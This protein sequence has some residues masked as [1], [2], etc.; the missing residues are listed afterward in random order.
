V[1]LNW[2]KICSILS[3]SALSP[4]G[5]WPDGPGQPSLRLWPGS[6]FSV[7][8]YGPKWWRLPP[9]GGH[10]SR[11]HASR[12]CSRLSKQLAV[13]LRI[14]LLLTT[15]LFLHNSW[16][17][18]LTFTRIHNA[19][20]AAIPVGSDSGRCCCEFPSAYHPRYSSESSWVIKS[21]FGSSRASPSSVSVSLPIVVALPSLYATHHCSARS[22]P[23]HPG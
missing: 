18:V 11:R 5:R 12:K 15:I 1:S 20:P 7:L 23:P 14:Q 13:D 22:Q 4:G 6:G 10:K 9:S 3:P 8:L 16:E 21:S 2:E 17:Y 19:E